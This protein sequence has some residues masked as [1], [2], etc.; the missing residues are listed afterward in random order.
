MANAKKPEVTSDELNHAKTLW[1]GFTKMMTWGTIG[2]I[3]CLGLM[4]IV[5]L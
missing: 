5:L 1:I 4:A 2:V 3:A